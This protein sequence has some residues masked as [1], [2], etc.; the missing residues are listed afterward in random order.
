MISSTCLGAGVTVLVK[1]NGA[2]TYNARGEVV[3]VRSQTFAPTCRPSAKVFIYRR[4]GFHTERSTQIRKAAQPLYHELR[5]IYMRC[6]YERPTAQLSDFITFERFADHPERD[7]IGTELWL[8]FPANAGLPQYATVRATPRLTQFILENSI[9]G[10]PN[11][12]R[13]HYLRIDF[14]TDGSA[15]LAVRYQHII[16]S[17]TVCKIRQADVVGFI[18]TGAAP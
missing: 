15:T 12:D 8:S 4:V 13:E 18:T 5:S 3:E 14:G 1:H 16:G 17:L 2:V 7:R 11:L 9:Y 10:G 6:E